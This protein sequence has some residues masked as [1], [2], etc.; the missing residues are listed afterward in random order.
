MG[1]A[2]TA[3]SGLMLATLYDRPGAAVLYSGANRLT[4]EGNSAP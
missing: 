4:V 1:G 3:G 2:P